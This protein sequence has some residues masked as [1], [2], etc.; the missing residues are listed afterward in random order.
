[1]AES[2]PDVDGHE[3]EVL[4]AGV[5]LMALRAFGDAELADE[6]AQETIVRAFHALRSSRPEQL[7]PF[8]AGIARH[9]ITDIIRAKPRDVSLQDLPPESEPHTSGDALSLLC[10][11]GEQTRVR[12]ALEHLTPEDRDLLRLSFVEGLASSEIAKR[13]GAPPER[14]RQRRHRALARLREAFDATSAASPTR[15]GPPDGAT[16]SAIGTPA[17]KIG[18]TR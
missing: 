18:S 7:G 9:V 2:Q 10:E 13:T 4:R 11:A 17:G 6:V 5:R 1:V 16:V 15:H 14:I 8:V 3:L 12:Q